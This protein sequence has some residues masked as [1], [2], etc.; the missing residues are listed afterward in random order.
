MKNKLSFLVFSVFILSSPAI[1][2]NIP[3]GFGQ[4]DQTYGD[5]DGTIGYHDGIDL[6]GISSQT[7][8]AH[9]GGLVVYAESGRGYNN[10]VCVKDAATQKIWLFGHIDPA[11]GVVKNSTVTVGAV[12][13]TLH[14]NA[15]YTHLHLGISPY[16]GASAVYCGKGEAEDPLQYLSPITQSLSLTS[17]DIMFT[18]DDATVANRTALEAQYPTA[19]SGLKIV[20]GDTDIVVFG[21]DNV[22]GGNKSG[23]Y[24]IDYRVENNDGATVVSERTPFVMGGS[25]DRGDSS[26]SL[27][28]LAPPTQENGTS[29]DWDNYYDITNS[30]NVLGATLLYGNIQQHAWQTQV[31]YD[32]N[33][34]DAVLLPNGNTGGDAAASVNHDV[35]GQDYPKYPDGLYK[36][37]AKTYAYPPSSATAEAERLVVVDNFRPFLEHT[38]IKNSDGVIK[39]QHTWNFNG[40]TL[41]KDGPAPNEALGAGTYT[42]NFRF[43]EPVVSPTL[44]ID[45]LG[46]LQLTSNDPAGN[47]KNFIAEFSVGENSPIEDGLRTLTVN[48]ADLAGNNLLLLPA[49]KTTINP[50]SELTRNNSGMQ[51]NAGSEKV[52][53]NPFYA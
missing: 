22:N 25:M 27:T 21:R 5:Y 28:Y 11:V 44:S 20:Y 7:V 15:D 46:D 3:T 26:I 37:K 53:F 16:E 43:S 2:L 39:Y 10:Y 36:I 33:D 13:G 40:T 35:N 34:N 12:V 29:T 19:S 6:P 47:Q 24:R 38:D 42:I 17:G 8:Q 1:A 23:V 49:D 41:A 45:T 30:K 18:P 52:N 48:A 32:Q 9:V 31:R 51:G 4:V 50:S 14:P